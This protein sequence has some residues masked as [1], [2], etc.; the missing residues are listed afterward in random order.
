M[1]ASSPVIFPREG[2]W[3][4]AARRDSSSGGSLIAAGRGGVW[5]RTGRWFGRRSG[6]ELECGTL[7]DYRDEE[8]FD[9]IAMLQSM[10]HFYDLRRA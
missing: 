3:T 7:E 4:W 6:L 5:S 2:C 8:Q 1:L 10:M 9:L